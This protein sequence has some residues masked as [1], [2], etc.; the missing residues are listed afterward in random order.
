VAGRARSRPDR[1]APGGEAAAGRE[2]VHFSALR[3][4]DAVETRSYRS[5]VAGRTLLP[6]LERGLVAEAAPSKAESDPSTFPWDAP[7]AD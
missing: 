7:S 4:V 5:G 2:A 3:R 6:A 1:F